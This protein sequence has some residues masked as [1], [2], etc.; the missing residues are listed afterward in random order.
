MKIILETDRLTLREFEEKDIPQAHGFYSNHQ[1]MQY[2]GSGRPFTEVQ[3]EIFIQKMMLRYRRDGFSFWG[4]VERSKN[5]LIGHCGLMT[6]K[7]SGK[8]ELG[9]LI[10]APYAKK[11]YGY[12]SAQGV[13]NH[14]FNKLNLPEIVAFTKKSNIASQ[15]L[16]E[17]LKMQFWR[18]Y[19]KSGIEYVSYSMVKDYH[20]YQQ[21]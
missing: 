6:H 3:T 9:Y 20:L 7:A 2:I 17:K 1:V 19:E 18:A 5:K 16:M 15:K 21:S 4:V 10:D 8:V 13:L 11:G 12:E 14:G